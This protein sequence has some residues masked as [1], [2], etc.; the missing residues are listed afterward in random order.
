[1]DAPVSWAALIGQLVSGESIAATSAAWAM[2]EI[3]AGAATPAQIAGFGIALR[4]K[5]E[6]AQEIG[7]LAAAMMEHA[8]PISIPGRLVDLVG[9][10]GDRAR[11]GNISRSEER[12]VGKKG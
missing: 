11:T 6:T 1:M 9:T 10:G 12:R 8:T 5:G 4:M 7:G 2:N 3:M